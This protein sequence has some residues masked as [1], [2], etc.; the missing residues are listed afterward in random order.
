MNE[1]HSFIRLEGLSKSFVEG[2]QTRAVLRDA[3]AEFARGEFV[4]ILGKSAFFCSSDP[5]SKIV[6][7][8]C[9]TVEKNGLG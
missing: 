8:L 2:G 4:A 6:M 9:K 3:D 1:N 5:P 7:P